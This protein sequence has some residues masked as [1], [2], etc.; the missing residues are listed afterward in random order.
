MVVLG[1]G[2]FLMCE[3]PLYLAS[4]SNVRKVVVQEALHQRG[5][6]VE[7]LA[8]LVHLFHGLDGT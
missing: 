3:V 7:I 6:K 2:L 8:E 1:G 4:E 5:I